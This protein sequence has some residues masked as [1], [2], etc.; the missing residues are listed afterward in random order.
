MNFKKGDRV[1]FLNSVDEGIVISV[2]GNQIEVEDEHGFI[3][4]VSDKELV[5][6][7]IGFDEL[8]HSYDFGIEQKRN[9]DNGKSRKNSDVNFSLKKG[10]SIK[11]TIL[12]IDLHINELVDRTG[13]LTNFQIVTIQMNHFRNKLAFA[14]ENKFQKVVF[15]HG[16]GEGVLRSEI[17]AELKKIPNC[18]YVDADF[19]R[20]GQGATEV[21][22]WYN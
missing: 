18:E 4:E 7:K 13:H 16:V 22:L 11:K 5:G 2:H 3:V 20:Y 1:K 17:R 21:N 19:S 9:L 15:I 12:E 14:F 6:T 8:H 10:R